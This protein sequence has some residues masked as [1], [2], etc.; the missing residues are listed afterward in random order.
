MTIDNS[1]KAQTE[2]DV[3]LDGLDFSTLV[4]KEILIFSEQFAGQP[5][6]SRVVLV[7][8]R[9]LSADR[10]GNGGRIDSLV[11][12]QVLTLRFDYKGEPVAIRGT[13]KKTQG[14]NCNIILEEKAK[15]LAL[16]KF[17]RFDMIV[18]VKMTKLTINTFG[19]NMF[20]KLRWMESKTSNI[21]AGGMLLELA[22]YLEAETFLVLNMAIQDVKF[23]ALVLGQIRYCDKVDNARYRTG[24]EFITREMSL[25]KF[26]P[27]FFKKLPDAVL[28]YDNTKRSIVSDSLINLANNS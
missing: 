27:S 2:N 12:N 1:M 5:L 25:N 19:R 13:L 7:K 24:I 9:T 8:D 4:G 20:A 28:E 23:P 17:K 16:R 11:N 26:E 6:K 21:S 10:S 15:P 18:P 14:G 22:G 3:V